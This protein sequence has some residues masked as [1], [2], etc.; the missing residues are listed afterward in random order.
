MA[1]IYISTCVSHKIM[2]TSGEF[3]YFSSYNAA[4]DSAKLAILQWVQIKRRRR[5][6]ASNALCPVMGIEKWTIKTG[7]AKLLEALRTR[8]VVPENIERVECWALDNEGRTYRW[9]GGLDDEPESRG[10]KIHNI[11]GDGDAGM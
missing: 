10:I 3:K 9:V 4:R 2:D 6:G 11:N 8:V 1:I 7:K 5:Q